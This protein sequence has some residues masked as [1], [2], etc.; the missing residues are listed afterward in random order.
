MQRLLD[1]YAV[2]RVRTTAAV[3]I[4]QVT[5]TRLNL[6]TSFASQDNDCIHEKSF[7]FRRRHQACQQVIQDLRGAFVALWRALNPNFFQGSFGM[8]RA[9]AGHQLPQMAHATDVVH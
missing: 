5:F 2:G 4:I 3:W 1:R 7:F 6:S 8:P 9:A